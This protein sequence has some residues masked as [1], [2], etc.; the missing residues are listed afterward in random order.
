MVQSSAKET[1]ELMLGH[2]GFV[3]SIEEQTRGERQVL[4]VLTRDPGRLI[5]RDGH[6][7]EELQYLL[8]RVTHGAEETTTRVVVDVEN[9]RLKEEQDFLVQVRAVAERVRRTGNPEKLEPMNSFDRRAVHQAFADDPD[10]CTVSEE[11]DAR[12]K[13]ITIEPRK[14]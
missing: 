3:F 14:R 5:G 9:Y 10:I 11:T 1:L 7:L 6:T 8:N 13:Q 2:L 4:N 12:L